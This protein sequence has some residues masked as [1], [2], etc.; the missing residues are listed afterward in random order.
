MRSGLELLSAMR[1][2]GVLPA[3]TSRLGRCW[4]GFRVSASACGSAGA[5][6]KLGAA[7]VEIVGSRYGVRA[8]R[9][10]GS[11]AIMVVQDCAE[12]VVRVFFSF[13]GRLSWWCK[14][15]SFV[16]RSSSLLFLFDA[17]KAIS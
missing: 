2:S 11:S 3:A 5:R 15:F 8:V 6:M 10:I 16:F 9:V 4:R 7:V 13:S 17:S 1:R 12:V 14:I